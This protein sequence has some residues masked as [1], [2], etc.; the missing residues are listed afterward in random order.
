MFS[1]IISTNDVSDGVIRYPESIFLLIIS[2]L[3]RH[4]LS[5]A[6]RIV[7]YLIMVA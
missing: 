1:N 4:I 5:T 6:S 2:Q 3:H 7:L